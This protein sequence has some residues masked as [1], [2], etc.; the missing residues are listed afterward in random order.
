VHAELARV[1]Q[2]WTLD[3]GGLSRNGSYLNGDAE[4]EAGA[5]H[6]DGLRHTACGAPTQ[7]SPGVAARNTKDIWPAS[8]P[9]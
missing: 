2:D 9:A 1:D 4:R 6:V 3:D 5:Q 8:S 7:G